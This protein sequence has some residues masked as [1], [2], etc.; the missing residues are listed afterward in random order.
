[1]IL[2]PAIIALWVGSLLVSLLILYAAFYGTKILQHWDL[3]SGSELQ[4]NLERKTY[5][6][7]TTMSY[8]FGY[9]LCALFLFVFTADKL[10]PLFVGAMCAAGTLHVNVYGYPT[11]ILKGFNFL[12]AGIWLVLNYTDNRATD[13]PLIK[14]KYLI[15]FLM[16]PFMVAEGVLQAGY[17]LKLN[18]HV[19]TSCCGSLFNAEAASL[20]GNLAALPSTMMSGIFYWTMLLTFVAAILF[21]RCKGRKSAYLLAGLSGITFLVSVAALISFIAVY[22]YELPTHHCPFCILQREYGYIGYP[23]YVTLFSGAISG[24]GLGWLTSFRRIPSLKAIIPRLQQRL[25]AIVL[26]SYGIFALISLYAI[27]RTDFRL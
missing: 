24:V 17:F 25:A 13:Y 10:S 7:S 26:I 1:M 3:Q 5:L 12:L 8:V 23:L 14:K 11:L 19:I 4:L 15:L 2:H 9:Q 16:A 18:P 20:G 27:L 6:I 22:I 21:L